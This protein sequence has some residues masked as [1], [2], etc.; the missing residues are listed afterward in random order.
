[1]KIVFFGTPAFACP[2]L[3]KLAEK[4]EVALVVT[5][6][7]S[8]K[9]RGRK[10]VESDVAKT[11]KDLGLKV[12]K[13]DQLRDKD[14]QDQ[15]AKEEADLYVVVA[16]GQILPK[17]VLDQ[18][19][20]FCLNIHGSILPKYRG[21]APIERAILEGEERAGISLMKMEEGLD[22]GPVFAQGS[23]EIGHKTGLELREDLSHLGA[24]LLMDF[25]P[26]IDQAKA[27][28]QDES[29]VTYAEKISKED[30]HLN[31]GQDTSFQ[32]LRK[33]QAMDGYKGA[34][35]T[36]GGE[37][38]KVF[39]A[40]EVKKNLQEDLLEKEEQVF[41]RTK[42]GTIQVDLLQAPGKKRMKTG[43]YLRGNSIVKNI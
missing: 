14:I 32:M 7:D 33:I 30:G 43:D 18:P 39:L 27:Q 8:Y 5:R 34:Y 19:K 13:T 31:L 23:L 42:D 40:R 20:Y 10:K 1:M 3:K 28:D 9:G 11:A 41:L 4:E 16:Y 2:S 25:L 38:Y 12:L 24:D 6:P 15:L 26:T 22:S 29:Q 37:N 35:F 21:A 36:Y 17:E